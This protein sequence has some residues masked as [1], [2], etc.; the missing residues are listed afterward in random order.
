M[1]I[2]GQIL[3][4]I[5]FAAWGLGAIIS[6]WFFAYLVMEDDIRKFCEKRASK[7]KMKGEVKN[8]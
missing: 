6:A 7:K 5:F 2:L 8:G 1:L 4:Y 3:F